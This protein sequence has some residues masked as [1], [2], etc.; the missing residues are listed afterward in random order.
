MPFSQQRVTDISIPEIVR[1]PTV[2][3][4][5]EAVARVY[6]FEKHPYFVWMRAPSTRLEAFRASQAPYRHMV[7]HFSRGL[8]AVLS[9]ITTMG[10]RIST[11]FSNVVEEHG[12]GE[13]PKSHRSTFIGYLQAIGVDER[14]LDDECP[15][16]VAVAY[17]S[18]LGFCLTNP[19]EMGAAAMGII[20]YTHIKIATM[21]AQCI[22]DR[23][24]G[25]VDAQHHYRLHAE[26]DA[27]H[28]LGLFA[29]CEDGW[30]ITPMRRRIAYSMAFGAHVFWSLFDAMCP[31]EPIP[32]SEDDGIRRLLD[33]GGDRTSGVEVRRPCP[34]IRCDVP[35][36]ARAPGGLS[37]EAR[38]TAINACGLL[39]HAPEALPLDAPVELTLALPP[40]SAP[41][42]LSGRVRSRPDTRDNGT[43]VEFIFGSEGE[44]AALAS[45]VQHIHGLERGAAAAAAPAA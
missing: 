27:D 29:L 31:A 13:Q 43:C 24:W 12:H 5:V 25:D 4:G 3:D 19:P 22:H 45:A 21:L 16:R 10:E 40:G 8:A 7:E 30:S 37:H 36:I 11:V 28:A 18:L 34:R 6:D 35:V 20:E 38:A 15:I 39:L 41:L 9:R 42:R 33:P 26:I 2:L 23:F 1:Q 14:D 17:E 32:P 44:R